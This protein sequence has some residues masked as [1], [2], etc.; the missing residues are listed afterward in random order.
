MTKDEEGCGLVRINM[1]NLSESEGGTPKA[2]WEPTALRN[3]SV[4]MGQH[5]HGFCNPFVTD[6]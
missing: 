5:L 2:R 1:F 6:F 3:I 4:E